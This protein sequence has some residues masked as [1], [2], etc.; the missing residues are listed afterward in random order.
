MKE[1]RY[2]FSFNLTLKESKL[3][4]ERAKALFSLKRGKPQRSRYIA[5]LTINE[6]VIAAVKETK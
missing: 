5:Y 6:A 1:K 3:I 2:T 4:T